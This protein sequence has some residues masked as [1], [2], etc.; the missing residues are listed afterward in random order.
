MNLETSP[1][2]EPQKEIRKNPEISWDQLQEPLVLQLADEGGGMFL[3]STGENAWY[4]DLNEMTWRPLLA[5]DVSENRVEQY[6]E[7]DVPRGTAFSNGAE[8]AMTLRRE[9]LRE[10]LKMIK[11]M[12]AGRPKDEGFQTMIDAVEEE[13]G[14]VQAYL[15]ETNEQ[16][17]TRLRADLNEMYEDMREA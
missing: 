6:Q 3:D 7:Y 16:E 8:A 11:A 5:G 1:G 15:S 14:F 10:Q 17:R 4:L 12:K 2:Y 9:H 13:Q